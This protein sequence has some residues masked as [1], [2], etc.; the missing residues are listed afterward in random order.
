[1]N[2]TRWEVF[3]ITAGLGS[4]IGLAGQIW[5]LWHTKSAVSTS[6]LWMWSLVYIMA[7]WMIYGFK[8]K[9]FALLF[10]DLICL[11]ETFIIIGLYYNYK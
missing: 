10:T 4:I 8:I 11:I 1:M 2:K 5:T 3:A 9:S 6:E 7:V